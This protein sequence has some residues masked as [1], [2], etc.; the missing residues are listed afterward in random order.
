M[1]VM[2]LLL[3]YDRVGTVIFSAFVCLGQVI[4]A[5]G[6][7]FNSF[8]VMLAGRFVFGLVV[9]VCV[10]VCACACVRARACVHVYWLDYPLTKQNWGREF[11]SGAE[12]LCCLLVQRERNQHG[13]WSIAQRG[14]TG[15][16]I[17]SNCREVIAHYRAV[18]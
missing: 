12:C 10:C 6:A 1:I 16:L 4:F 18:Q 8:D 5:L 9:C 3:S 13:V 11:G 15:E 14:P 17:Y 2:L 7:N